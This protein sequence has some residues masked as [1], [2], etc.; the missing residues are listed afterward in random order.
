MLWNSVYQLCTVFWSQLTPFF[1]K[2]N[3]THRN[4]I[5]NEE[6]INHSIVW[7]LSFTVLFVGW[8]LKMR[9][10]KSKLSTKWIRKKCAHFVARLW[11]RFP[12]KLWSE[13]ISQ[14]Q[15]SYKITVVVIVVIFGIILTTSG[16]K[17]MHTA[18]VFGC[19]PHICYLN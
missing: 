12:Q 11:S 16:H 14:L 15:C 2:W 3:R 6:G 9:C 13:A 5:E 1:V 18:I 8:F 4:S 10:E 7:M 19:K 17:F